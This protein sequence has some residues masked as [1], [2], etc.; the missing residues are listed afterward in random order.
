MARQEREAPLP[1]EMQGRWVEADDPSS[2][3]LVEGGEITCFSR[4]VEYDYKDVV[5]EDEALTVSLGVDDEADDDAFQRANV[6]GLVITPEGELHAY[7]VKFAAQFVRP[8]SRA[9]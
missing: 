6:T 8:P 1:E 2:E 4:T 7:N 5:Q 3:L 9:G